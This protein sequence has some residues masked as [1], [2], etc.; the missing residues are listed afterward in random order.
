MF[1]PRHQCTN[2]SRHH[3]PRDGTLADPQRGTTRPFEAITVSVRRLPSSWVTAGRLIRPLILD[4]SRCAPHSACWHQRARPI[5][6][7]A[8]P[9]ACGQLHR[10]HHR[11]PRRVHRG[12]RRAENPPVPHRQQ[13]SIPSSSSRAGPVFRTTIAHHH[14]IVLKVKHDSKDCS[15]TPR[16]EFVAQ[17]QIKNKPTRKRRRFSMPSSRKDHAILRQTDRQPDLAASTA[18]TSSRVPRKSSRKTPTETVDI[19]AQREIAYCRRS[20]GR[21]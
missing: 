17:R 9:L 1:L 12:R 15:S 14:I 10:G 6:F 19:H 4:D 21:R 11:I 8:H 18:I 5:S 3:R 16:P 13:L 2:R 20:D 7:P